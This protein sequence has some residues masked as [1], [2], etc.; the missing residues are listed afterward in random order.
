[1]VGREVLRVRRDDGRCRRTGRRRHHGVQPGGLPGQPVRLHRGRA[2]RRSRSFC[3]QLRK[4]L[5]VDRDFASAEAPP[6]PGR[7]ARRDRGDAG[8]GRRSRSGAASTA[9]A[10]VILSERAGRL[11]P[12]QQD[13]QRRDG[14]LAGG[15]G[16]LRQRRHP[17]HRRLPVAPQGGAARPPGQRRWP[18]GV[19]GRHREHARPRRAARRDVSPA[20][21]R[22]LDE[23]RRHRGESEAADQILRRASRCSISALAARAAA[24]WSS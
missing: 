17:D 1:M 4:R 10:L 12:D 16:A 22:P 11:P 5:A 2:R 14:A 9:A 18:A 7:H 13:V 20:A 24:A 21:L 6:L 3:A 19:P 8:H 15:R 23:R